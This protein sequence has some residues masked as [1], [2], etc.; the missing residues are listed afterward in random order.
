MTPRPTQAFRAH[1]TWKLHT[2]KTKR[3]R[4]SLFHRQNE[5][6]TRSRSFQVPTPHHSAAP[7]VDTPQSRTTSM[8]APSSPPS[9]AATPTSPSTA[10]SRPCGT[11]ASSTCKTSCA[12]SSTRWNSWT[13]KTPSRTHGCCLRDPLTRAG[14]RL[15]RW[16]WVRLSRMTG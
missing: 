9:L 3:T 10:R 4:P 2:P 8:A 12:R 14:S 13:C 16:D 1:L 5:T 15:S 6:H 7:V 11:A